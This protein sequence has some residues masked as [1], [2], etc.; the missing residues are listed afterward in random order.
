M[1]NQLRKILPHSV[2]FLIFILTSLIYFSPVLQGKQIFQSDIVQYIGMAKERNDFKEKTG[3]ESYWTNSAFGGMPTYQLGANYPHDY[4]KKLDKVI[5]FLPRPADY[6][7][8]YFVGFY[9]LLM[10][11]KVDWKLA[12]IGSLA[13]GF[14]TYLIIILGVG[15]NAKAHAIGYFAFVLAGILLVFQRKY[16]TGFLLTAFALALEINANHFQMTYYLMFLVLIIGVTYLVMAYREKWLPRFFKS[17]GILLVAVLLAIGTNAPNLLATQ[18]YAQWSTRGPS[19]LTINPDGS[20]KEDTAGLDKEYITQYSYGLFESFNLLIPRLVGGGNDEALSTDSKTYDFLVA[21]GVAPSQARDFVENQA[22]HMMYWGDQPGVAAPA[23]LGAVILLL[24]VI[25]LV[26][27]KGPIKWWLVAGCIVSL[28]LSWGHNFSSLTNFMIDYFPLYNKFRAITSIQVI[29][30]LCVPILATLGL[31]EF[32]NKKVDY[33]QKIKALKWGGIVCLG[34]ISA[35]FLLKGTFDYS[36]VND[37]YYRQQFDQMGLS[38]LMG[39]IK[40]DRMGLLTSDLIRNFLLIGIAIAVLW[41]FIKNKLKTNLLLIAVGTL[42]LIDLVGVDRHYV[43]QK[44]FVSARYLSRPFPLTPTDE[45]ILQDKGHYRVYNSQEGLNGASTSYYHK[46]LGGYH[47]AK[48]KR[49]S[50]LVEYQLAKNNVGILNML[51][52]KYIIRPDDQGQL[53]P[54]NNPYANGPAWFVQELRA[55]ES[56]DQEM[57]ALDSINTKTT[58]VFDQTEFEDVLPARFNVDS[59]AQITLKYYSPNV[60]LYESSNNN[61]GL[62]VFSEMHYPYGWKVTID[63]EEVEHFRVDYALRALRIPSGEHEIKFEFDP[64]VVKT[65]AAISLSSTIVLFLLLLSGV[66]FKVRKGTEKVD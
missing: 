44:D 24:F 22:A 28:L 63:G 59:T 51:N 27:I 7:F 40:E 10:V 54:A 58:A 57:A 11:L 37:A 14:S 35:I 8:L 5:R 42:I 60:L 55:V 50:D 17:V 52:V 15:H 18:E 2:V 61:N 46:S 66:Y 26:L 33:N 25:G 53:Y 30:E 32:L 1:T 34:I 64:Q 36:H 48:P 9:V 62:A 29:I 19:E 65:G 16:I 39:K 43:N 6:L 31:K 12:L 20:P 47:A 38:Q 45:Q 41:L 13:F 21:Q 4:V 3:E 49:L 23:Y 56:P